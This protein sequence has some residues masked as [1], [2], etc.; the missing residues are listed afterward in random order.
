MSLRTIFFCILPIYITHGILLNI[1]FNNI[2]LNSWLLDLR[3]NGI[4]KDLGVE[5]L[6]AQGYNFSNGM[7]VVDFD[8][9]FN[10]SVSVL[11]MEMRIYSSGGVMI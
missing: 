8:K 2:W 11:K 3:Q 1:T 9:T 4:E 5:N 10:L 6:E 7:L